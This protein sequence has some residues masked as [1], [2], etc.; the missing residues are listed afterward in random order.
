MRVE[1]VMENRRAVEVALADVATSERVEE[2]QR[3][4]ASNELFQ[5]VRPLAYQY[6]KKYHGILS[7]DEVWDEFVDAFFAV[8]SGWDSSKETQG[9]YM[10]LRNSFR[11]RLRNRTDVLL[12][13]HGLREYTRRHHPTSDERHEGLQ[14]LRAAIQAS[15]A[16]VLGEEHEAW[17]ASYSAEHD[18][19]SDEVHNALNTLIELLPRKDRLVL[20]YFFGIRGAKDDPYVEGMNKQQF[21]ESL[22]YSVESVRNLDK[23]RQKAMLTLTTKMADFGLT[24]EDFG[25][26]GVE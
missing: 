9:F 25:F 4:R 3:D 10:A 13:E 26:R 19:E 8:L 17:I 1:K 23:W 2:L 24:G 21:V 11:Y 16:E 18:Y 5:M 12:G 15:Q 14:L 20:Q 6:Q 22:G 7:A